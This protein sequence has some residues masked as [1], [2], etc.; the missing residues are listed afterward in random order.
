MIRLSSQFDFRGR[1]SV[2]SGAAGGSTSSTCTCSLVTFG[3][4]TIA[5]SMHFHTLK[6]A[7][8]EPAASLE[9]YAAVTSG[10]GSGV[11][12]FL[13]P[14]MTVVLMVFLEFVARSEVMTL[15]GGLIFWILIWLAAYGHAGKPAWLAVLMA[16]LA[17]GI[18]AGVGISEIRL[19]SRH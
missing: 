17:L 1:Y 18:M 12:G 3:L 7:V 5:T 19:W 13:L 2:E 8:R 15:G 10:A 16:L 11:L 4:T 9:P 6:E 14:V